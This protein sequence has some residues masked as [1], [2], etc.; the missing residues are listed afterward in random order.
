MNI[1]NFFKSIVE[2]SYI[3]IRDAEIQMYCNKIQ[4]LDRHNIKWLCKPVTSARASNEPFPT[5]SNPFTNSECICQPPHALFFLPSSAPLPLHAHQVPQN[6]VWVQSETAPSSMQLHH[7]VVYKNTIWT[8]SVWSET[9]S[10]SWQERFML[11]SYTLKGSN[12]DTFIRT[13]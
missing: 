5:C 13:V 2:V 6:Q 12:S 11:N 7:E 4:W 10:S 9:A 8:L 1:F 3:T